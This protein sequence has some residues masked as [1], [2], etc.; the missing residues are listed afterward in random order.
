MTVRCSPTH[1]IVLYIAKHFWYEK[2]KEHVSSAK[3]STTKKHNFQSPFV[4]CLIFNLSL[5]ENVGIG[6]GRRSTQ[7]FYIRNIIIPTGSQQA[8][9]GVGIVF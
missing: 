9:A 3:F 2:K 5:I 6:S 8:V 1:I 4:Y 7:I